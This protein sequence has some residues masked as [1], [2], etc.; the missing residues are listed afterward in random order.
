MTP[1][2][3]SAP[4]SKTPPKPPEHKLGPFTAGIG[5]SIWLNTVQTENG[6]RKYRSITVNPRRYFDRESNQ[7]RDSASYNLADLPALIFALQKAQEY[8]YETSLPGE[9][10][11]DE[12]APPPP[13]SA[14][15]PF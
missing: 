11:H 2:T 13:P 9:S 15:I 3:Q 4:S 6:P 1:K 12:N 10:S 7:W 5:V 8:V 14:D